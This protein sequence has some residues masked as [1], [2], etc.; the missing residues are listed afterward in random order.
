MKRDQKLAEYKRQ[1]IARNSMTSDGREHGRLKGPQNEGQLSG[2][3]GEG[4]HSLAL[5]FVDYLSRASLIR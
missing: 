3:S 1:V 5:A 4:G 2:F